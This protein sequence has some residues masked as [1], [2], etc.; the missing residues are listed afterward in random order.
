MIERILRSLEETGKR[1]STPAKSK[2]KA[3]AARGVKVARRRVKSGSTS[4]AATRRRE[5]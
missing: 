5:A 4:T 1:F 3:R 2:G